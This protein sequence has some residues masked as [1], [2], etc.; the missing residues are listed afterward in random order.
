MNQG[1]INPIKLDQ[2]QQKYA[3]NKILVI[4]GP[5]GVGKDTLMQIIFEKYPNIL[6]KGV[7]HTSRKIR[8]G[9]KE[10]YNYYY[11]TEEEFLKLIDRDAFFEFNYYN[12]NYYGISKMELENQKKDN[13]IFYVIIAIKG[14]KYINECNIPANFVAILPPD[15]ETL[16]KRLKGR[17]TES[18]EI[19]KARLE[20]AK[21]EL[22]EIEKCDFFTYRIYND[23]LND[24]VSDM[25]LFLKKA[26]PNKF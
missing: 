9:E 25:E 19:I 18:E 14:A 3:K 10:G 8:K 12:K 5:S 2:T 24:A 15:E 13:K 22:K 6:K 17:G 7:T 23:N 16:N 20:I 1:C 26:Y 11:V 21:S 4:V